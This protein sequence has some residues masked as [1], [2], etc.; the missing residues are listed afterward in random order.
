MVALCKTGPSKLGPYES[1]EGRTQGFVTQPQTFHQISPVRT[2]AVIAGA[3][4]P[5]GSNAAVV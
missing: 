3:G 2:K 4:S 5:A 1:G